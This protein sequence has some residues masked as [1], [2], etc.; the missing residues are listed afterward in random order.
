MDVLSA[1]LAV[2][3]TT[4]RQAMRFNAFA[5]AEYGAFKDFFLDFR[6]Q[7]EEFQALSQIAQD[8]INR[9]ELCGKALWH[10]CSI[11]QATFYGLQVP[12]MRSVVQTNLR[13]LR[14]WED[15]LTRGDGLPFGTHEMFM[16][17]VHTLALV[18]AE[19]LRP[20]YLDI[21]ADEDLED[22]EEADKLLHKLAKEAPVLFNFP[23]PP[24][25]SKRRETTIDPWAQLDAF[26]LRLQQRH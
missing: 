26:F 16:Q 4:A 22:A 1:R 8:S 11:M 12:L 25:T 5:I 19:L 10:E 2:L 15:R 9:L 13:L 23:E 7:C 18:R 24:T 6:R 17:T 14:V 20:R 21:L 3:E